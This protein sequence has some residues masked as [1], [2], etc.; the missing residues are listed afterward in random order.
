[1]KLTA[2]QW[3]QATMKLAKHNGNKLQHNEI[4]TTQRKQVTS[5]Q[6]QATTKLAQQ[7]RNKSQQN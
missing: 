7:N 1:M 2:T 6:K 5:Q 4:S 3:K